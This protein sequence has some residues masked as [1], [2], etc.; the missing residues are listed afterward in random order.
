MTVK[1]LNVLTSHTQK[2]FSRVLDRFELLSETGPDS[3]LTGTAGLL[4]Y[5]LA[6]DRTVDVSPAVDGV[7]CRGGVLWWATGDQDSL[8][9]HTL[10]L[11]TV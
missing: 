3:D 7:F 10:D 1:I 9:W 8:V 11:R 5:D 2:D 6:T 4:I